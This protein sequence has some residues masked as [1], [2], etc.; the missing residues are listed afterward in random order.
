MN[1]RIYGTYVKR[2]SATKLK[3]LQGHYYTHTHTHTHQM[4]L[5]LGSPS[6]VLHRKLGFLVFKFTLFC[7]TL[8]CEYELTTEV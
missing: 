1:V 5:L 4:N 6:D 8:M 2:V 3:R 7:K